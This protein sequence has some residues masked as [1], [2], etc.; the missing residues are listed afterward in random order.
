MIRVNLLPREP[1]S[2]RLL[3]IS[4]GVDH[5]RRILGMV[6]LAATLLL[7]SSGLQIWREER[8]RTAATEAEAQLDLHAD[9]R[10]RVS[11]LAR[12]VALFQ[13]IERESAIARHSGNLAA[14]MIARVGNAI[15]S[16]AWLT[17][18]DRRPDGYFILGGARDLTTVAQTLDALDRVG[19]PDRARLAG[20]SA[21]A[22]ALAFS[23]R[24]SARGEVGR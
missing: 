17:T 12:E 8:L 2:L 6:A 23:V 15:P 9:Q 19:S 22:G 16:G 10:R 3:G 1:Q 5:L 11:G 18:L 7:A 24:L 4:V 20:V 21:A 13:R 14:A